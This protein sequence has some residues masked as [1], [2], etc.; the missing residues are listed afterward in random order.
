MR[1]VHPNANPHGVESIALSE[2]DAARFC[3]AW[4]RDAPAALGSMGE[5]ET[6]ITVTDQE[7]GR[8]WDLARG[9]CGLRCR[10][11]AEIREPSRG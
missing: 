10:C 5:P 11:A 8:R 4:E 9:R 1:R 6:W 2:E 3:E 7:T